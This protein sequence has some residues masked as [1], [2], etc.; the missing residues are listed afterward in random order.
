MH[1]TIPQAGL[2]L[3]LCV[4]E[5]VNISKS[6]EV[7]YGIER[8]AIPMYTYTEAYTLYKT[9]ISCMPHRA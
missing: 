7:Y 4:Y 2:H 9:M 1:I 5:G 3:A 6:K 8:T